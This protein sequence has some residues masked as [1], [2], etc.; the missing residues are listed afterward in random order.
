MS[1]AF[2]STG[3]SGVPALSDGPATWRVKGAA[4]WMQH[5]WRR[6]RRRRSKGW[7]TIPV[8][9]RVPILRFWLEQWQGGGRWSRRERAAPTGW[10]WWHLATNGRVSGPQPPW[11]H[12][13]EG[14]VKRE[15]GL[16][17][18]PP[19]GLAGDG[20]RRWCGYGSWGDCSWEGG[21]RSINACLKHWDSKSGD[22][23]DN[24]HRTR[25][26][27]EQH[28]RYEVRGGVRVWFPTLSPKALFIYTFACML[29][30]SRTRQWGFNGPSPVHSLQSCANPS[31]AAP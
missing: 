21:G 20:W 19:R 7:R 3:H 28:P 9:G 15:K 27:P 14:E 23:P 31:G 30:F 12:L 5:E 11:G 24:R 1:C 10:V 18:T 4:G 17:L 2:L 6:K 16:W 26:N 25:A 8:W 22:Q 29:F 13:R